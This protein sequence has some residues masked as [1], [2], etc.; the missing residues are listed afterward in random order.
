MRSMYYLLEQ[1]PFVFK[2]PAPA[3]YYVHF[4]QFGGLAFEGD[5][6]FSSFS[7]GL[8]AVRSAQ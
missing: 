6:S 1:A 8:E 7:K 4:D 3:G 5:V 2:Q